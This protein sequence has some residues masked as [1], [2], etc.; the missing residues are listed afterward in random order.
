[1]KVGLENNSVFWN[2]RNKEIQATRKRHCVSLMKAEEKE[3]R[4][5]LDEENNHVFGL[6]ASSA[7]ISE[8]QKCEE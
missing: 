5:D 6:W 2:M 7:L 3:D 1:M 4:R 8:F